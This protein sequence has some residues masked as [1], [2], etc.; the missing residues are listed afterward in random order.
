MDQQ[1]LQILR[2]TLSPEEGVRQNAEAQ[3]RQLFLHPGSY[4]TA[5]IVSAQP[6]S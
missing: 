3:L 5:G 6:T 2:E 4:S 1:V